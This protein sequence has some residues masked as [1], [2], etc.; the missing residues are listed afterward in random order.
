MSDQQI[1]SIADLGQAV[2]RFERE[3]WPHGVGFPPIWYRGQSVGDWALAPKVL[4]GSFIEA[5]KGDGRPG[6]E[7]WPSE[8]REQGILRDFHRMAASLVPADTNRAALYMLAQHHGLPTRLLD[9]T[10]NALVGLFNAVS[11]PIREDV[12]GAIFVINAQDLVPADH[13]CRREHPT[14]GPVITADDQPLRETVDYLFAAG[15]RPQNGLIW[16]L[17]PTLH[18]GRMFQQAACFTLHMPGAAPLREQAPRIDKLVVP[19]ACK[20]ELYVALRRLG[21]NWATL[22]PDLDH[23]AKEIRVAYQ[24][25]E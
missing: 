23:I 3:Y 18:Q 8:V 24:L 12:D 25:E 11:S 7:H 4:R 10:T 2:L 9:W 19:A 15:E 21:I 5:A 1:T 17:L 22:F 14:L 20:H 13:P 6:G 16:P